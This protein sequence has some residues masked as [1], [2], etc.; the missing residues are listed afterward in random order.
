[1]N[2]YSWLLRKRKA[3]KNYVSGIGGFFQTMHGDVIVP[4]CC[5]F[6][7]RVAYLINDLQ[8][9]EAEI[10]S[11]GSVPLLMHFQKDGGC[12][13]NP[14]EILLCVLGI[15]QGVRVP[16]FKGKMVLRVWTEEN[17]EKCVF[18]VQTREILG[19]PWH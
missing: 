5:A 12:P 4:S 10:P 14:A 16:P 7:H 13:K 2:L 9:I 6:I 3:K 17:T 11:Q 1:M 8:N 19:A 18:Q 15:L